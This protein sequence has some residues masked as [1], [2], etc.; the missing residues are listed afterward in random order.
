[1]M[2]EVDDGEIKTPKRKTMDAENGYLGIAMGDEAR[3]E[4]RSI[5][6]ECLNHTD[7]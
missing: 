5:T 4:K 2:V 1:M 3:R 7:T 6:R